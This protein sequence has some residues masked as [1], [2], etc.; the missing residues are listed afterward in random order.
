[1]HQLNFE[2]EA[3]ASDVMFARFVELDVLQGVGNT[4][5]VEGSLSL[6][7]EKDISSRM[8]ERDGCW[9]VLNVRGVIQIEGTS[10]WAR[11][12]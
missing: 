5:P 8:E 2:S 11:L 7:R 12:G 6:D 4:L 1:M 10:L 9:I 3:L